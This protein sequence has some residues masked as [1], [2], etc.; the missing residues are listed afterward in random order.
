MAETE[1]EQLHRICTQWL[2][3][4]HL[5]DMTIS[6]NGN[7][8]MKLIVGGN[9]ELVYWVDI[10]CRG[11]HLFHLAKDWE[12]DFNIGI[13]IG[14]AHVEKFS[15]ENAVAQVIYKA[16]FY[17]NYQGPLPKQLYNLNLDGGT[18]IQ[19]ICTELYLTERQENDLISP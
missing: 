12:G 14:G 6:P 5:S 10:E 16:G 3:N 2:D 1:M 18:A 15:S 13:F 7:I 4:A 9:D 17:T 19:V 8:L 11:V